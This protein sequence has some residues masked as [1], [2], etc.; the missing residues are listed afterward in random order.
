MKTYVIHY[1]EKNEFNDVTA[2]SVTYH[3]E[4]D[5]NAHDAI[6]HFEKC[7]DMSKIASFRLEAK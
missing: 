4:D 5:Q 7:H 6:T 3:L 2:Y 1:E